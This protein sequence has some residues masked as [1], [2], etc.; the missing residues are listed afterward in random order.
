MKRANTPFFVES[1]RTGS[2]TNEIINNLVLFTQLVPKSA[3]YR[4]DI[5]T[6]CLICK[7]HEQEERSRRIRLQSRTGIDSEYAS[8]TGFTGT[9]IT[10][11]VRRRPDLRHRDAEN[12]I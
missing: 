7:V 5:Y 8:L 6:A 9:S 12:S 2:H 3:I 10:A 4:T 11:T 1:R